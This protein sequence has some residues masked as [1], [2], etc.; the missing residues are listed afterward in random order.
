MPIP[1]RSKIKAILIEVLSKY[2]ELPVAEIHEK[3]RIRFNLT[4]E[5]IALKRG[6]EARYKN[7][8]RWARLEL[9]EEG[10]IAKPAVS[11]RGI[12]KL[13]SSKF[14]I[15]TSAPSEILPNV[16]YSEGIVTQILV[17][18]YERNSKARD[19]CL[20]HY[21]FNCAICGFD[22]EKEYGPLGAGI[23]QV[24]HLTPISQ[25]GSEYQVDPIND[26][27]PVCPNCHQ[28]IHRKIPPF[29]ISEIR[30]MR[31]SAKANG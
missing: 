17:N 6:N 26:L 10:I 21:G 4:E 2:P 22:F 15:P 3:L 27:L 13:T 5:E 11:R 14:I 7:E 20:D 16:E 18:K 9:V 1:N 24:H 19:I 28:M 30:A 25:I 29:T 23:I 12:W 31:I 8:I